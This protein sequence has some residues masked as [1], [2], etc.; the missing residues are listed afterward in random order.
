MSGNLTSDSQTTS[1]PQERGQLIC[2]PIITT[3]GSICW[4]G[5]R[6]P[7]VAVVRG[8]A[9]RGSTSNSMFWFTNRTT[10]RD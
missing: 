5:P 7:L 2:T 10:E 8:L 6:L 4:S 1:N 9:T 3:N